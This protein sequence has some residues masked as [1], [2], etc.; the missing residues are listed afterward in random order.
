MS[1]YKCQL[2]LNDLEIK[3]VVMALDSYIREYDKKN[4]LQPWNRQNKDLAKAVRKR[5]QDSAVVA[6]TLAADP[7]PS[8][9][10]ERRNSRPA[11]S[12]HT[13]HNQKKRKR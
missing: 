2:D 6:V 5:L 3:V 12:A 11:A 9:A 1:T 13:R 10:T 8:L 7:G 4:L